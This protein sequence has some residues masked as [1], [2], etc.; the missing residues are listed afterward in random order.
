MK[1][2]AFGARVIPMRKNSFI[3]IPEKYNILKPEE[4]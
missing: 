4:K 2:T 1:P 3:S